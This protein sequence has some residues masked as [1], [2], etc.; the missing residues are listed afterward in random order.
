MCYS[1]LL[2]CSEVD[3]VSLCTAP[4]QVLIRHVP[5]PPARLLLRHPSLRSRCKVKAKVKQKK[6]GRWGPKWDTRIEERTVNRDH[7]NRHRHR[8]AV[9]HCTAVPPYTVNCKG[10]LPWGRLPVGTSAIGGLPT[11]PKSCIFR[12]SKNTAVFSEPGSSECGRL[13]K[14]SGG[15]KAGGGEARGRLQV[16]RQKLDKVRPASTYPR[17]RKL[18]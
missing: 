8:P 12:K 9:P 6:S 5:E 15:E 7:T 17:L 14:R 1:Y 16:L 13:R 10:C 18:H 11:G 2:A 4:V 3:N